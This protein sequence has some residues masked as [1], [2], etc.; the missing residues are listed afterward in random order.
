MGHDVLHEVLAVDPLHL[1]YVVEREVEWQLLH[2][3]G[4]REPDPALVEKLAHR[5]IERLR[6]RDWPHLVG[7][8]AVAVVRAW[9]EEGE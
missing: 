9:Q 5:V 1:R 8:W 3:A 7:F 2:R 4:L 6:P